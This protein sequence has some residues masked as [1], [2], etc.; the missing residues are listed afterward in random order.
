[1]TPA[2]GHEGG[3]GVRDQI[4]RYRTAF[5]AVV[6]MILIAAVVGGYILA[7][8]NLKLPSW[9]PVLGHSYFTLQADFQTAQAVTPGQGQ[10]VTIAGAKIGEIASVELHQGI[11]V[12]TMHVTPKYARIYRDATLLLRPKTQLKDMTVEVNPGTPASGSLKSG[13]MIPLAQTAP[14]VNFDEFISS[15]DADTRSYLQELLAGA[16]QGLKN[17]GQALSAVLKRFSPTARYLQQIAQQVAVRH[18]NVA[19]AIHNFRLLIE[20]LGGKD[21][22]LAQ[23]VDSSNA[24]FATFAKEEQSVQSTLR[25]LPGALDK[26]KRGLGKLAT[27]ARVLGPTLKQLRP[28]ASALGPAQERAQPFFK[29]TTPIFK[30]EVRPFARQIL[31]VINELQ[32]DT[33][34]LS[35]VFPK[36]ASSFGVFNELFNEIAYNPGTGRGGFLFFLG[37]GAHDFNSTVGSADAHG[38]LGHTLPYFNC[39]VVPILKSIGAVNPTARLLLGL[40]NPPSGPECAASSVGAGGAAKTA[41]TL[42]KSHAESTGAFSGLS[43]RVFGQRPAPLAKTPSAGKAPFAKASSATAPGGRG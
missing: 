20:A 34:D 14:D 31:P 1:M 12:V 25:L 21:K 33:R 41:A 36:L 22:Q 9:V 27:A 24:V 30:N 5:I 17:N 28:F 26:T 10:A 29:T 43:E 4:E 8:E 19:H 2:E 7:H 16:G 11:A 37:W 38:S 13:A 6:S 15:L 23:F 35:E 42:S 39:N 18:A 3:L 40:L 32:P